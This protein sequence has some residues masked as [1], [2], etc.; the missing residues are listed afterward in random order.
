MKNTLKISGLLFMFLILIL[1]SPSITA[2]DF[3][4]EIAEVTDEE[5]AVVE[6]MGFELIVDQTNEQGD[7]NFGFRY[8]GNSGNA[9]RSA[10][11]LIN[12]S[13]ISGDGNTVNHVIDLTLNIFN[14][15]GNNITVDWAD[16]EQY[17]D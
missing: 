16:I 1:L 7:N 10:Q 3:P 11:G 5:L 4:A 15:R 2:T 13:N 14:I 8:S 9:F 17:L 12:V 6:G